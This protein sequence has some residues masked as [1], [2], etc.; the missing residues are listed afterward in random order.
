MR[1]L[2]TGQPVLWVCGGL[3]LGTAAIGGAGSPAAADDKP[4]GL[5]GQL[6]SNGD[7]TVTAEEIPD[8]RKKFFDRLLQKGDADGDGKLSSAEFAE[9]TGGGSR[10][11]DRGD[12][13]GDGDR[14][15]GPG[16]RG[17][18]GGRPS[19][20]PDGPKPDIDTMFAA[21]D[22]NND[23]KIDRSEIPEEG[24]G[25]MLGMMMDR[26]GVDSVTKDDIKVAMERMQGGRGMGDRGPGGPGMGQRGPGG[27]GG[28]GGFGGGA[29]LM[30][31]LDADQ[32]GQ[33]SKTEVEAMAKKFDELDKNGDGSLDMRELMMPPEMAERM[34]DRMG[35]GGFGGRPGGGPGMGR[36]GDRG[37]GGPG[38]PRGREGDRGGRPQ[39]PAAE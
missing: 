9:V 16:M 21:M 29:P 22:T 4:S 32:D 28:R 34:G 26:Q 37:R 17:R 27:P 38:G 10:G 24:R 33:L 39:R 14:G 18:D 12:R 11:G 19:L 20:A 8:S 15:R 30:V 1:A 7:G 35:R 2:F 6:D 25:R 5:F 3:L 36:G 31:A 13:A 23:G